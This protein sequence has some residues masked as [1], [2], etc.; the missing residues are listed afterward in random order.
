MARVG[1]GWVSFSY[2]ADER[3]GE[4][5]LIALDQTVTTVEDTA[6]TVILE[7]SYSNPTALS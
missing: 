6:T 3:C 1:L 5:N 7:T 2:L 4:E